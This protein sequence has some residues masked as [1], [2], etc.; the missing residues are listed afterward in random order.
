LED[1]QERKKKIIRKKERIRYGEKEK[2]IGEP[3]LTGSGGCRREHGLR[4][5]VGVAL[6]K[7][8]TN[9]F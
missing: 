2:W 7:I 9:K 1:A 8:K 6:S 4:W 3:E 5:Y